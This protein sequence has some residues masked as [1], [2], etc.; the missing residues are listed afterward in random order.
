M[1]SLICFPNKLAKPGSGV[2]SEFAF[3]VD[4]SKPDEDGASARGV[5]F[6]RV[7]CSVDPGSESGKRLSDSLW[8]SEDHGA[9]ET[10]RDR[11]PG[12]RS[13]DRSG[14][15]DP[16]RAISLDA[17]ECLGEMNNLSGMSLMRTAG[18]EDLTSIGDRGERLNSEATKDDVTA[19]RAA[20]KSCS[21]AESREIGSETK[22][23]PRTQSLSHPIFEDL[24]PEHGSR[25]ISNMDSLLTKPPSENSSSDSSPHRGRY[26]QP[27]D[28]D[29][30]SDVA[31]TT[32]TADVQ[33]TPPQSSPAR[34][35]LVPVAVFKG[36]FAVMFTTSEP[37]LLS[38]LLPLLSF[39]TQ[40]FLQHSP[41]EFFSTDIN[42]DPRRS[43]L[44]SLPT[45]FLRFLFHLS[46]SAH[47]AGYAAPQTNKQKKKSDFYVSTSTLCHDACSINLHH[48]VSLL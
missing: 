30:G 35:S 8:A 12:R 32:S 17:S 46:I 26:S 22:K 1:S 33:K 23:S 6:V 18:L 14:A 34:K 40:L 11:S 3:V 13:P 37:A 21:D 2:C 31:Q 10:K 7:S 43:L 25:N 27:N 15:V 29:M 39:T 24:P 41:S 36:L 20:L 38:L 47:S 44:S 28:S 19:T 45:I 4:G 16:H 42:F 9:A 48:R 5:D